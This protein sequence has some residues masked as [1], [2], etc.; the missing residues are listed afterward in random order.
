[1]P[2]DTWRA[3]ISNGRG[4]RCRKSSGT[5]GPPALL[6]P[7]QRVVLRGLVLEQ[8]AAEREARGAN[9]VLDNVDA[10]VVAAGGEPELVLHA[11]IDQG[12]EA[13]H[14]LRQVQTAVD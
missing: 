2:R 14:R 8:V 10:D 11:G 9:I 7:Q 4:R 5:G 1:M 3:V 13:L 6:L 12:L